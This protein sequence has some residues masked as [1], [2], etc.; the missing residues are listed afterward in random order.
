METPTDLQ[1]QRPPEDWRAHFAGAQC[2]QLDWEKEWLGC[3]LCP[4]LKER[5]TRVVP[6]YGAPESRF[7]FVGDGPGEEEDAQGWPFVGWPGQC[8]RGLLWGRVGLDDHEFFLTNTVLCRA[9]IP[10]S[11]PLKDRDPRADE[12]KNCLERLHGVVYEVDPLLIVALGPIA[13][14]ALTGETKAITK[15]RGRMNH[16]TIQGQVTEVTYPVFTTFHPKFLVNMMKEKDVKNGCWAK[17]EEDLR[18]ATYIYDALKLAYYGIPM[19]NREA[20]VEQRKESKQ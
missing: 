19:P 16:A 13:L 20:I 5:R 1:V 9:T 17:A 11:P 4:D 12:I 10:G 18:K 2:G 15:A 7:L 14:R 3:S 6:G 8:F